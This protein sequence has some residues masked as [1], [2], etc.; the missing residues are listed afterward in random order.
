[1]GRVEIIYDFDYNSLEYYKNGLNDFPGGRFSS[2]DKFEIVEFLKEWQNVDSL[3][4]L[5]T[6]LDKLMICYSATHTVF[7]IEPCS[8]MFFICKMEEAFGYMVKEI[9][10]GV[11][12]VSGAGIVTVESFFRTGSDRG[13]KEINVSID[14]TQDEV[15]WN[16]TFKKVGQDFS[17]TCPLDK[18]LSAYFEFG[19]RMI[20]FYEH[21][22]PEYREFKFYY[23]LFIKAVRDSVIKKEFDIEPQSSY[24]DFTYYDYQ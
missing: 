6:G 10:K 23:P 14:L 20:R 11:K 1:M 12:Q 13:E 18:F 3:N 7:S 15:G 24:D 19:E 9:S 22:L 16:I 8:G 4:F 21:V 5:G 17:F 2:S